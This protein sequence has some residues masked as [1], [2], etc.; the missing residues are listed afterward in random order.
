MLDWLRRLRGAR[1]QQAAQVE[2]C[3]PLNLEDRLRGGIYGALLGDALGVPYENRGPSLLPE[4]SLIALNPPPSF[5]RAHVDAPLGAWSDDGAQTLA[6]LD[7]LLTCRGYDANDFCARM[8]KWCK[9]GKYG[10]D[11]KVFDIGIITQTALQRAER[12]TPAE[13]CGLDDEKSNGNGSLMRCLP[14]GLYPFASDRDMVRAAMGQSAL[15][16]RHLRS[17]LV[18]ALYAFLARQLL[19]GQA[20]GPALDIAISTIHSGLDQSWHPEWQIIMDGRGQVPCGTAYVVDSFWSA[21]H[22]L[23]S[24]S[25]FLQ[26]ITSAVA[27]GNDTDTTACIAGGIAGLVYG[28]QAIPLD[29]LAVMQKNLSRHAE[30]LVSKLVAV[31]Q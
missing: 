5:R 29:M 11:G 25:T 7:S 21:I 2:T 10:Y 26:V 12:G 8:L 3:A 6:L 9:V 30:P 27:L 22:C 15:T 19:A 4:R 20:L 1:D 23:E 17:M 13:M 31:R 16:H 28:H 24:S 14:C 18:C